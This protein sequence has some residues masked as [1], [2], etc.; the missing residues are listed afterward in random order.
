M[1]SL[2]DAAGP[3][4]RW[5]LTPPPLLISPSSRR[6]SA[7]RLSNGDRARRRNQRGLASHEWLLLIA[8]VAG[9]TALATFVLAETVDDAV[10]RAGADDPARLASARRAAAL[11]E[12][13]AKTITPGASDGT[14]RLHLWGEWEDHFRAKCLN[15]QNAFRSAAITVTA[16]FKRPTNRH[17]DHAMV[18]AVAVGTGFEF[19]PKVARFLARADDDPPADKKPQV[20]CEVTTAP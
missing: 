13:E 5:R 4:R 9:F 10:A 15:I 14:W 18:Q 3:E 11:V 12:N 17:R 8:A 7:S 1:A 16:E 6:R 20:R 19:K 2:L